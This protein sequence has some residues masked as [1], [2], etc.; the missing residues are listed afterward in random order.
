MIKN[1]KIKYML[2]F[3]TLLLAALMIFLADN[4][5]DDYS[6]R[7]LNLSA[8]YV[9]LGI[10]LNL[11]NGF[12]GLFSL[13]HAGFMA[14]GAYTVA[15]LTMSPS[16][17]EMNFYMY[18]IWEPLANIQLPL[19]ISLI[20]AGVLAAFVALLIGLPTLRLRGD[21]LAIATLG[22][23]EIIRV[24]FTNTTTI[25]NG[26]LGLKGIPMQTNLWW[27]W[28]LAILVI[29]IMKN[30]INS[31]FGKAFKAIRD[32]EI[33]AEAMGINIFKYKVLSFMIGAFF[34]GVGGALL[35]I[36]ITTINPIMFR[37][38]L[39]FQVL[40]IVVIGGL[41]SITGSVI[42]GVLITVMMEALRVV[43][44]PLNLGFMVIP[45]I[46]GMRMVI[47]SIMLLAVILFYRKGIMGTKEFNWDWVIRKLH[48]AKEEDRNAK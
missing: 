13:G 45:G 40:M 24:I 47:F 15:L 48:L 44:Q 43:E 41:G 5:L 37:F 16:T 46:P 19:F 2:T 14:I 36:L 10:S 9:I 27:N 22:F 42:S 8:I 34:A 12:T 1:K 3:G 6:I 28:G 35:A 31:S 21:Y 25:T 11:I 29:F 20:I 17:K 32:D 30:I 38:L 39:T 23:G 26:A 33:A 4:Y 7:I 18:S